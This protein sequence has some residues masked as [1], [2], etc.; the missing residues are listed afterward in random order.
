MGTHL[1]SIV[2]PKCKI[3]KVSPINS[4]SDV[5]KT[6][7]KCDNCQCEFIGAL[8]KSTLNEVRRIIDDVSYYDVQ[9]IEFLL[10]KLQLTLNP[11]HFLLMEVKQNLVALYNTMDLTRKT[12][13]RKIDLCREILR[14]LE[15][16]EPGIS[17]LQ[18]KLSYM[19]GRPQK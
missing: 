9:K 8:I 6:K 1:S 17:R 10:R 3:G 12:L 11:N 5:Y 13:E 7:W 18:G 2:C 16:I 15:V 14:V 4:I 19:R